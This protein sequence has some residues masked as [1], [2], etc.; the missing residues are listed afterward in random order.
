MYG[1][2]CIK[3]T[4]MEEFSNSPPLYNFLSKQHML[5]LPVVRIKVEINEL[6]AEFLQLD[7]MLCTAITVI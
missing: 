1:L 6:N 4:C 3:L 7:G 5:H 2:V